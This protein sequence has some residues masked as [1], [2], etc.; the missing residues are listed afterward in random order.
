MGSSGRIVRIE[1]VL[2]GV[3]GAF[4]GGDFL[5]SQFV[6]P[7]QSGTVVQSL[8]LAVGGAVVLLLLLRTMRGVV[9]PLKSKKSKVRR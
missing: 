7:T 8:G 4:I 5:L 1:E 3:F 2:V 9:G 6:G